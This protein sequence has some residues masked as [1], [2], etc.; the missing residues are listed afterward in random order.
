MSK[1]LTTCISRLFSLEIQY[2]DSYIIGPV[3]IMEECGKRGLWENPP[4]S[5][6]A[7]M[8][9]LVRKK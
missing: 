1:R 6:E 8:K 9:F 3:L 7:Y 4:S 2:K 5:A